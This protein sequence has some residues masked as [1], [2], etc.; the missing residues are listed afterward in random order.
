MSTVDD[1]FNML[2]DHIAHPQLLAG[3]LAGS[4]NISSTTL[5]GYQV[6]PNMTLVSSIMHCKDK[7]IKAAD[8]LHFT[9]HR[10]HWYGTNQHRYI[11][12]SRVWMI[13]VLQNRTSKMGACTVEWFYCTSGP[14]K[15]WNLYTM[16]RRTSTLLPWLPQW[17]MSLQ[18]PVHF[19]L[20]EKLRLG[21]NGT[22]KSNPSPALNMMQS[23]LAAAPC[24]S[25]ILCDDDNRP[26]RQYM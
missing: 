4:M 1:P 2:N 21:H 3:W 9:S 19:N 23:H 5:H 16:R 6:I 13:N 8:L 11:H 24:V 10:S 20:C 17:L 15:G 12:S 18:L 26:S 14:S 7:K 22:R 25:S